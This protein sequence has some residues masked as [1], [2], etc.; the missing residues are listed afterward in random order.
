MRS[1]AI[2]GRQQQNWYEAGGNCRRGEQSGIEPNR[3]GDPKSRDG[4]T[5][6]QRSANE[7][8]RPGTTQPPIVEAA[9]GRMLG[10]AGSRAAESECVG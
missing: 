2:L 7:G 6:Q 8:R 1:S 4:L 5:G 10:W 3:R 9:L